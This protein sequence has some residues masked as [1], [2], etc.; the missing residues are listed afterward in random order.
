M[1]R[2]LQ[3]TELMDRIGGASDLIALEAKYHLA[4]LDEFWNHHRSLMR[5]NETSKDEPLNVKKFK[6]R[7]LLH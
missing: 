6:A 3:E 5:Q 4:R 2:D 1:A 7:A